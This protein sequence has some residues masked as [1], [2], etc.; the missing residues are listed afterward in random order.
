[1][2]VS[3]HYRSLNQDVLATDFSS[4]SCHICSCRARTHTHSSG[5]QATQRHLPTY[6]PIQEPTMNDHAHTLLHQAAYNIV[7]IVYTHF[8]TDVHLSLFIHTFALKLQPIFTAAEGAATLTSLDSDE[9]TE[10]ISERPS[11]SN[12]ANDSKAD[13][14]N[15]VIYVARTRAHR[16]SHK[17]VQLHRSSSC[18]ALTHC[19]NG[20]HKRRNY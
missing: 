5:T 6:S 16:I 12:A 3:T 2:T 11:S 1:M 17:Q 8:G 14:C 10:A 18:A 13:A 4:F 15:F 7:K 20:S 9:R 19:R